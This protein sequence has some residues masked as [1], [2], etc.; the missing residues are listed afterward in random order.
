V[1]KL[2]DRMRWYDKLPLFGKRIV[3]TRPAHQADDTAREILDRGAEP[4]LAPAIEIGPPP[5]PDAFQASLRRLDE[6]D[7]VAFTS[8]NGV[9]R[10]MDALQ[11][12]Q[13]D[14]RAFGRALVAAVGP[15]TEAALRRRG[16]FADV[17]A[18]EFRGEG[19][20]DAILAALALRSLPRPRVLLLRALVARDALPAAL[21]ARGVEVDVVAAY[22]TRPAS[23]EAIHAV[24]RDLEAGNVDAV[25]F[26]ASS[27]VRELTVALGDRAQELLSRTSSRSSAP[28]PPTRRKTSASRWACP[29]A[30]TRWR[31]FLTR[32]KT[33]SGA[34]SQPFAMTR[35]R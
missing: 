29:R 24:A 22:A 2:R 16:I 28:S 18:Q 9:D 15:G 19:L 4:I 33:I 5:D 11:A 34:S 3:V 10:S 26:T 35:R 12:E 31:A 1:A 25:M 7:V 23:P 17:V 32:S 6:Y 30:S 8:A 21:A 14:A 13:R 27:T 20:A